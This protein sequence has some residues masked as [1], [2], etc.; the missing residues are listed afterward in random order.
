MMLEA[1]IKDIALTKIEDLLQSNGKSLKE[2]CGMP[3]PSENL[4]P[5]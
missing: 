1:Q 5:A 4:C 2:Y 3:Y